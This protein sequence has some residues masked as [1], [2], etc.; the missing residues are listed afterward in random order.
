[1]R[2][3]KS[4]QDV[5]EGWCGLAG[6]CVGCVVVGV[7]VLVTLVVMCVGDGHNC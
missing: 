7:W 2:S 6:V 3:V 1:M 5:V 4:D